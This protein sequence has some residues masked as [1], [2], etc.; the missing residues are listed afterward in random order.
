MTLREAH[1]HRKFRAISPDGR[2]EMNGPFGWETCTPRESAFLEARK[3]AHIP[4]VSLY[5]RPNKR[6]RCFEAFDVFVVE[7]IRVNKV[8]R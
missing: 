6:A 5:K 7:G 4:M 2:Y 1:R 8:I 3:D